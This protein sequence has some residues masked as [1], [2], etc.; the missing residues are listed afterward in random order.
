[1]VRVRADRPVSDRRLVVCLTLDALCGATVSG[2]GSPL[3]TNIVSV[4][5]VSFE[6]AQWLLTVTL[7]VGAVTIPVVSRLGDGR[8]RRLVLVG[9]LGCVAIGSVL[10]ALVFTFP[11]L[12]AGRALQGLGYGLVPLTIGVAREHLTGAVLRRAVAMLSVSVAVGAGLANPLV[13]VFVHFFDYRAAFLFAAALATATAAWTWRVLPPSR[14][15]SSPVKVDLPA[16]LW[17]GGGLAAG[18]LAVSRGATWGWS[19]YPVFGLGAAS[20]VLLT[21]WVVVELRASEPLV[22]IRLACSPTLLGVNVTALFTGAAVFGGMSLVFR[23]SQ[24]PRGG[25]AGLGHSVFVAGL[26]MM[27]MSVGSLIGPSLARSVASRFGV[28]LVLPLG[29]AS[30]ALAYLFFSVAHSAIWQIAIVTFGAGIGIGVAYSIMPA[31]IVART[32]LDRTSSATG[33][34]TVLRITGGA[35]GSAVIAAVLAVYTPSGTPFPREAGY[36]A[37]ALMAAGLCLACLVV[38]AVLVR[39]APSQARIE[40]DPDVAV[41]MQES[42]AEAAG[43]V[44]AYGA[45]GATG[46]HGISELSDSAPPRY[47]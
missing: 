18:L 44:A 33:L 22:D 34:N 2:L 10:A 39:S 43:A 17:L 5:H 27:P 45:E 41:L 8:H 30:V 15:E 24:A 3:V 37:A 25:G 13:G 31:L 16:A 47:L 35:M 19:S 23:L 32:P 7:V 38:S 4:H 14:E 9:A 21:I 12:L 40:E 26:L 28:G 1:V 20:V 29:S 42:A 11:A 36:V 46:P 6:A